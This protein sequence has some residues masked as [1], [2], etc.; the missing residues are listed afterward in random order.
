MLEPV[1]LRVR[2]NLRPNF[3]FD[4]TQIDSENDTA[5]GNRSRSALRPLWHLLVLTQP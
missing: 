4:A 2:R 3:F 5:G 1:G